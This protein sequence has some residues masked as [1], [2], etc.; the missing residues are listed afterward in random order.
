MLMRGVSVPA[1]SNAATTTA[2]PVSVIC[3]RPGTMPS[4]AT[5]EI[6]AA[7]DP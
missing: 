5:S 2:S 6:A 3:P 4:G 1:P 7:T